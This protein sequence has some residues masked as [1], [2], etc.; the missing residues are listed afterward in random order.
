MD[1]V[2]SLLGEYFFSS[3]RDAIR[4]KEEEKAE[5][6]KEEKMKY[7]KRYRSIEEF[8]REELD[9]FKVSWSIDDF[10]D[11]VLFVGDVDLEDEFDSGVQEKDIDDEF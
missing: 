2:R 8:A 11:D 5:E 4:Q 10:F 6:T 1:E 9:A 7:L 3:W